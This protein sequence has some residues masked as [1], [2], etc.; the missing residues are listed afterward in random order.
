MNTLNKINQSTINNIVDRVQVA[1]LE[2]STNNYFVAA[3]AAIITNQ[4]VC[5]DS[6]YNGDTGK[7]TDSLYRLEKDPDID[8]YLHIRAGNN[9]YPKDSKAYSCIKEYTEYI[10]NQ[11]HELTHIL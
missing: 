2:G 3:I 4:F 9:C 7:Y 1:A 11:C 6:P 8:S 10:I 5:Y